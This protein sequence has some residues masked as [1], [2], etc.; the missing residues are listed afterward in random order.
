MYN[1][2]KKIE[3]IEDTS[4]NML[5]FNFLNGS[6]NLPLSTEFYGAY[7]MC[8]GCGSGKTT[9]IKQLIAL[10]WHEG[11]L[12]SAFT[13]DEVNSMY[14]YCKSLI[15]SR[16]S[17]KLGRDVLKE[18][19]IIVLHSDNTAEGVN[20]EIWKNN[21]EELLNKKII[22]CTHHKLLNEPIQLLI[23][24]KFNSNKYY[25]NKSTAI[26][27]LTNSMPRQ[28]I[29]IDEGIEINP[30]SRRVDKIGILSL[31][32]VAH[33]KN[34]VDTSLGY[35]RF[36]SVD[37]DKPIMRKRSGTFYDF[38]EQLTIM[39][40]MSKSL[41]SIVK[42]E[43]TELDKLRNE[44][45]LEELFDNYDSYANSPNTE[46]VNL[47]YGFSS[48]SVGDIKS[49]LILFD[50]TSD[51]TLKDSKKFKLLS[52]PDKYHGNF[53]ISKFPFNIPR[54]IKPDKSIN[55]IDE[56]LRNKLDTLVNELESI[57]RSN[58]KTLIFTWKDFKSNNDINDDIDPSLI[59]DTKES[60]II[61][62]N[63]NLPDYIKTRLNER[64][65]IEGVDFSIEYYGSGRDKAIN[66]YRDYDA[67]VLA[68][69]YQV[70][71]SVISD[72]NLSYHTS[73]GEVDYYS[74][75]VIQAI[76]RVRIRKHEDLP[77]NIYMSSD[78][79][80]NVV[81]YVKNYLG[82]DSDIINTVVSNN[83]SSINYM[84]NELRKLGITPKK[85]EKIA[86]ISA[87]DPL[88][89]NSIINNVRYS[90]SISLDDLYD[91]M[92]LNEKKRF[93]Y[94]SLV[95]MLSKYNINLDIKLNSD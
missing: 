75:R 40:T 93:R 21:P 4:N 53:T 22:L 59:A 17:D 11:I 63:L 44:Q 30:V 64:G 49:H 82:I 47:M 77:V 72:F 58:E 32:E 68:G 95:F 56:Y 69:K 92:P 7:A 84:Y 39:S 67:V 14:Q 87:I 57:I 78:W 31:G 42:D 46:Y 19:D 76:C 24:T 74:N 81:N 12:Y 13:K 35:L 16:S 29:L 60:V 15:G 3:L 62:K 86:K 51:I 26:K 88:I 34:I 80:V 94:D 73:I 6:I 91:C 25:T 18:D 27:G 55:N 79:S 66:D 20:N 90:T 2:G 50:G 33:K 37:L 10:K 8:P 54:T 36:I 28:W 23:S 65:L 83:E 45:I 9:I 89:F 41:K 38:K 70:P 5:V 48:L 85:S 1:Q 71:S 52:Y 61:N 43:K